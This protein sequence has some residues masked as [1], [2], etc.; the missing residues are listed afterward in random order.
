MKAKHY[1]GPDPDGWYLEL[2]L[3]FRNPLGV[4]FDARHKRHVDHQL[5]E[6]TIWCLAEVSGQTRL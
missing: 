6:V 3:P 1:A 5:D 4:T 2:Q